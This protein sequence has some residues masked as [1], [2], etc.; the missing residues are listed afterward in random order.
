MLF[1]FHYGG[2]FF[3]FFHIF[4]PTLLAT[5]SSMILQSVENGHLCLIPEHQNTAVGLLQLL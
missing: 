1:T 3:F 2:L 4:S 5:S